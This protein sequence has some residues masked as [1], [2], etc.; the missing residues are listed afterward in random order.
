MDEPLDTITLY[1]C[2]WKQLKSNGIIKAETTKHNLLIKLI[3]KR[4]KE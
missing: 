4:E 3:Y 1:D 2:D